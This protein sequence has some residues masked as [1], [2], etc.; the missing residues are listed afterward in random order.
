MLPGEILEKT[1]SR[2]SKLSGGKVGKIWEGTEE[3]FLTKVKSGEAGIQ[4]KEL[5]ELT[6]AL[7][8]GTIGPTMQKEATG[9]GIKPGLQML[10]AAA[11]AD[12]PERAVLAFNTTGGQTV[13]FATMVRSASGEWTRGGL[14]VA[15]SMRG[16][17]ARGLG[18]RLSRTMFEHG[19]L[20]PGSLSTAGAKAYY[21]QLV[22]IAEEAGAP[23]AAT[24]ATMAGIDVNATM[25]L[26]NIRAAASNSTTPGMGSYIFGG[27]GIRR[28]PS[29]GAG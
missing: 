20:V 16:G 18:S 25:A 14:T 29:G 11:T 7:Q 10:H 9:G 3:A 21:R 4:Y 2:L 28:G 13:G 26:R 5:E 23:T 17:G 22:R 24:R 12:M 6:S 19:A 1:A 15:E 27:R 8:L